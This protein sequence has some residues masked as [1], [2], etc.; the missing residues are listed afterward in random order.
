MPFSTSKIFAGTVWHKRLLPKEHA[1]RYPIFYLFLDLDCFDHKKG[2]PWCLSL[3][4]L[5]IFSVFQKDYGEQK[6]RGLQTGLKARLKKLMPDI[7][8]AKIMMLTMP[9]VFGYSFNPL[10]VYYCYNKS[11]G[12]VA[13]LYE[14]HNTFGERH[15]YAFKVD[16]LTGASV[17]KHSSEKCF[18]VSPFF[19]VTG[20]YHFTTSVSRE[21]LKLAIDYCE[22]DEAKQFSALLKCRAYPLNSRSLLQLLIKIPFVTLKTIV[23]IHFEAFRIWSKGISVFTKPEPPSEAYSFIDR[24]IKEKEIN[25]G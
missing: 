23:A 12:L 8:P 6:T 5:N 3:D 20:K 25:H 21:R 15:T 2:L 4:R 22:N 19:K 18:H 14:V 1:F 24:S 11:G 10:T 16:E 7:A 9:R 17:P 13:L